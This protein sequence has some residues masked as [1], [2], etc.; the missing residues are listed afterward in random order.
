MEVS[1]IHAYIFFILSEHSRLSSEFFYITIYFK[2]S[3]IS[4]IM[5]MQRS[6]KTTSRLASFEVRTLKHFSSTLFRFDGVQFAIRH[7]QVQNSLL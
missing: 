2:S 6:Y 4:R 7:I 5:Q 1:V 3:S